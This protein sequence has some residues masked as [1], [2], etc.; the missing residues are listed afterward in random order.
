MK[1]FNEFLEARE[2]ER[3]LPGSRTTAALQQMMTRLDAEIEQKEDELEA[4][5]DK[6]ERIVSGMGG[7]KV[8]QGR[9]EPYEL[10]PPAEYR[11]SLTRYSRDPD[12]MR[13]SNKQQAVD[14]IATHFGGDEKLYNFARALSNREGWVNLPKWVTPEQAKAIERWMVGDNSDYKEF[15]TYQYDPETHQ[16]HIGDPSDI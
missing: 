4:L 12:A 11:K 13:W 6:Q 9:Y 8:Y 2:P 1:T 15:G 10:A 7:G 14:D 16:F 5:R 3:L